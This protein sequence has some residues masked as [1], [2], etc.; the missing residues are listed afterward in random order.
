VDGYVT[1]RQFGKV[2]G[3]CAAC[4]TLLP[5]KVLAQSA[6]DQITSMVKLAQA[7]DNPWLLIHGIRAMGQNF[8]ISDGSTQSKDKKAIDYLCSNYLLE[9]SVGGRSYFYIPIDYERHPYC[10]LSEAVLDA[11]VPLDYTF[12]FND[13]ICSVAD[14]V[15][16]GRALF[17]FNEYN[18]DVE[19]ADNLAWTLTAFA[20]VTNPQNDAWVNAYGQKIQLSLVVEAAIGALER[21]TRP[22]LQPWVIEQESRFQTACMTLPVL[23]LT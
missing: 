11:D 21:G 12:K 20:R 4:F 23:E 13:R 14:L 18:S 3:C 8:S 19:I 15:T 5:N 17:R 10:F 7:P 1:R 2:L 22:L 6:S 9:A 16:S